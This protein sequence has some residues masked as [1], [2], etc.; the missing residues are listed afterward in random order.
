[1]NQY[2]V[3]REMSGNTKC[4]LLKNKI[5]KIF[6]MSNIKQKQLIKIMD[7]SSLFSNSIPNDLKCFQLPQNLIQ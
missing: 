2:R 1:M 3:Y 5:T 7:L 6:L 4:Y